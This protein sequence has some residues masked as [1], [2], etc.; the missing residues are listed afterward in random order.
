MARTLITV[1]TQARRGEI[2]EL[3]VLIQHPMETGYRR[4]SL[5]VMLP[6]DLIRRFVCT[7]DQTALQ[8]L[9]HGCQRQ[10]LTLIEPSLAYRFDN[11][12][13]LTGW[14]GNRLL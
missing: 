4:S 1:P 6:R 2:I 7:F 10:C 13:G 14:L 8:H 3:R 9:R 12:V 5:G 11:E